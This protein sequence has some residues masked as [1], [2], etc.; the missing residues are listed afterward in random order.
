MRIGLVHGSGTYNDGTLMPHTRA[1][2]DA[3]VQAYNSKRDDFL[4]A[5][6]LNQAGQI[7]FYLQA[8]GVP[9]ESIILEPDSISSLSNLYFSKI[10]ILQKIGYGE[11][12]NPSGID[13]ISNYW[14]IPRLKSDASKILGEY[15]LDYIAAPDPRQAKKVLLE[16]TFEI[17]K[18]IEER[19]LLQLGYGS[20][21]SQSFLLNGEGDQFPPIQKKLMEFE[22]LANRLMGR[23]I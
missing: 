7:S 17:P 13:I 20:E 4:I 9:I 5:S 23:F 22:K 11:I 19:Y 12:E 16:A 1:R 6:G 3:G 8:R 21:V 2:A 15:D 14:H 18:I 10:A